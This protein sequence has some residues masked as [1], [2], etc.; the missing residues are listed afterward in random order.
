VLRD[1]KQPYAPAG[2]WVYPGCNHAAGTTT[3]ALL[4]SDA[5]RNPHNRELTDLV[6]ELAGR[7]DGIPRSFGPH[8]S[9][10]THMASSTPHLCTSW[11]PPTT[12]SETTLATSTP[13]NPAATEQPTRG[14][15]RDPSWTSPTPGY[16]D[17]ARVARSWSAS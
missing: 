16:R 5:G 8:T 13:A 7:S 3:V 10:C 4:R 9:A 6:G 14:N 2:T 15:R 17:P 11:G 1:G 12:K